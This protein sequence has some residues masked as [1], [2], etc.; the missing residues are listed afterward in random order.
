[1]S[2][3]LS[4]HSSI[5]K[6][7]VPLQ[8]HLKEWAEA[9]ICVNVMTEWLTRDFRESGARDGAQREG[10]PNRSQSLCHHFSHMRELS[11]KLRVSRF[12]ML[13]LILNASDQW[14]NHNA[15]SNLLD[16]LGFGQ[17]LI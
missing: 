5:E 9:N 6:I 16:D 3:Y 7:S 11:H 17:G 14:E 4:T 2:R 12:I 8:I 15:S 1:M 13:L 10:S